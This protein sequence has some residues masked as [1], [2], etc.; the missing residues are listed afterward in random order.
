MMP[1]IPGFAGELDDPDASLPRAI[2]NWEYKTLCRGEN[3][4][5]GRLKRYTNDPFKYINV[6]GLRNH[7]LLDGKQPVTEIVYLHSKLM[8]VDD[9]YLICGSANINDRSM[10]G[11]R[12]SELC[13]I[14]EGNPEKDIVLGTTTYKVVDKIQSLRTKLWE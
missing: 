11:N 13:L 2:L 7:G 12:D 3:S 10:E 5:F 1:L 9:R 6:Y 4:L 14:I 8:I